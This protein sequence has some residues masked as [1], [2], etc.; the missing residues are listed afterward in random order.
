MRIAIFAD[1]FYPELSGISD[2]ILVTGK[3]LAE[4]GHHITYFV[5][6]YSKKE[7]EKAGV[8]CKELQVHK[9]IT[10]K[11]IWSFPYRTATGQGRGTIP[12]I[13][14]GLWYRNKFDVVHTHS[15]FSMGIEAYFF[16]T[17]NKIPLVGTNHT[18]IESF[19]DFVPLFVRKI[20]P[21]YLIWFYNRCTQVTTP[22][23]F[24]AEKMVHDGL[25]VPHVVISNPIESEFFITPEQK[26]ILLKKKNVFTF[27]YAG[28]VS[29][30]KNV[31]TIVDAFR[32]FLTETKYTTVELV[33]VG[34]GVL[35]EKLCN[36]IKEYH[37]EDAIKIKGP[38][39]GETKHSLYTEFHFANAFVSASTSDTQSMVVLQAMAASTPVL[40]ANSGPFPDLVGNG[41]RGMIFDHCTPESLTH[42]FKKFY[43][44]TVAY[45][46]MAYEAYSYAQQ[47]SV[48]TVAD[49][50]DS[51]YASVNQ[52]YGKKK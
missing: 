46:H 28:R 17:I 40:L 11:R 25:S 31:E 18:L 15:F 13:F 9:N 34:T 41:M 43:N 16:A 51:I 7:Y 26:N 37:L 20:V 38:F 42:A 21:R 47:F 30:E 48:N 52:K 24:L 23:D 10:I 2:S 39:V 45:T 5:P 32:M 22:T 29:S 8:E 44:S 1:N 36:K 49:R 4:R 50:W 19:L 6:Y 12:N 3:A 33:L 35:K 27:L 14:R